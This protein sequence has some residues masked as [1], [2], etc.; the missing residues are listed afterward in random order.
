MRWTQSLIPTLRDAPQDA[1]IASHKL[2][3]RAGLI[4]KL[5]GGLY[6]FLPLG[7]KALRNV[8]RIVR[9]EMDRAGALEVLM[10][11]LQPR[12]I[13]E[14]SGR[15]AVLRDSMFKIK[16]RQQ[17]DMVL[18]P[19]NEEVITDLAARQ[20]NS[21]RQLPKTFYQI[22]T[23]FRDEIRPRFGLMR[24]KE[25]SMKD[26]YSFDVSWE[27]ADISYQAM[28]DA[29]V[30]IFDRCGLVAKP[31]EA[32]TGNIGGNHS[33]EFMVLAPSGED[34]ILTCDACG[35]AANQ[36][37][38]ERRTAGSAYPTK[39]GEPTEVPTP[40][41]RSVEES[42]KAVGVPNDQIVKSLV[43]IA[44]GLPVMAIVPGTRDLNECKLRRILGCSTLAMADDA[45]TAQ[46]AGPLGS[47]GPIG[48]KIPVYA[49]GGLKGAED[50]VVG[51][52]KAGFHLKH[53][54][55]EKQVDVTSWEDL[56]T[57]EADDGCPKCG[58]PLRIARGIEVGHVFKLG[59]KYTKA[60]NTTFLDSEK[61]AKLMVMGCYGI[62]VTRTVQAI[63]EQNFDKDGIVWP[64]SVSPFQVVLLPLDAA[65]D[66]NCRQAAETLE[67]EL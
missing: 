23:K 12:E 47:I 15:Y 44:D 50:V 26:A 38:A 33:H 20:I 18:G 31:V 55:I 58:K 22:Q 28:Y 49:D 60:F 54:S 66:E 17:R 51:A 9:E 25:F 43:Y 27:A 61:T 40:G 3:M 63:V 1:E 24:A 62:G 19:T 53:V 45:T 35:Y 39:N 52:N 29:Y 65:K 67:R 4:M 42:A 16:D 37:R 46:S 13:W 36:E 32:D 48:V 10:P 11:A 30:R 57:V 21:Y 41:A 56:V 7:L 5:G 64:A 8:E 14:T 2:M 59:T 34:G 6:T